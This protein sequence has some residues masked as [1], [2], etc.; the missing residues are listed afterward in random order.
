MITIFAEIPWDRILSVV[1]R[2]DV[3]LVVVGTLLLILAA[4]APIDGRVKALHG[5]WQRV[6]VAL[7]GSAL[8][9]L[10]VSSRFTAV[11]P[12]ESASV[13]VSDPTTKF[14][15]FKRG[16]E[17]AEHLQASGADPAEVRAFFGVK[18]RGLCVSNETRPEAKI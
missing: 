4:V 14:G 6:L 18:R 15:F 10:G 3:F 8:L 13:S 5:R 2:V 12:E 16:K 1:E 9:G 17:A 11:S 7:L